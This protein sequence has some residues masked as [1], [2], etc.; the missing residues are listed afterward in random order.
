MEY[1]R[2]VSRTRDDHIDEPGLVYSTLNVVAAARR[3]TDA[4]AAR[5]LLVQSSQCQP[6]TAGVWLRWLFCST[7][8]GGLPEM[9]GDAQAVRDLLER[10][11]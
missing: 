9:R 10:E 6:C 1:P 4:S 2:T 11:L 8:S 3:R 5:W 7:L